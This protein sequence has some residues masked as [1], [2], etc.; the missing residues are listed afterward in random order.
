[1]DTGPSDRELKELLVRDAREGWRVFVETYTPHLLSM[2]HQAGVFREDEAMDVYVRVCEHLADNDCARLRR[3]DPA[4]GELGAWLRVLVRRVI[5]DWV[6]SRKG[7]RRMFQGIRKLSA[8]DQRVFELRYWQHR[9]AAEI[10]E[11]LASQDRTVTLADVFDSLERIEQALSTRQ[12]SE[13]LASVGR[14][15]PAASLD[16]PVLRSLS[17]PNAN[18]EAAFSS[19]QTAQAVNKALA[20]MPV[21]DALIVLFLHVHGASRRDVE[22]AL[23]TGPLSSERTRSILDRLRGMLEQRG[24]D[25]P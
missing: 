18:A 16:E 3:H 14:E 1:M 4:K 24:I 23:H 25:T 19:E 22:R 12:R 8:L 20:A 2:I 9:Q 6:R 21:E 11:L 7:R 15:R 17:A 5:V 10:V 13:L